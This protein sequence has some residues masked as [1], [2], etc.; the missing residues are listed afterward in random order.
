MV[1]PKENV[2]S[3]QTWF[4][5]SCTEN[6]WILSCTYSKCLLQPEEFDVLKSVG[7]NKL[8]WYFTSSSS[9]S[10]CE[11]WSFLENNVNNPETNIGIPTSVKGSP[12]LL[13]IS[14]FSSLSNS[15]YLL[16]FTL[17]TWRLEWRHCRCRSWQGTSCW[18]QILSKAMANQWWQKL[19]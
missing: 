11:S 17:W 10:F 8:E 5:W 13:Y 6:Q 3:M 14:C 16:L 12:P 1:E 19:K 7:H 15:L 4:F 9:N 18:T 2:I